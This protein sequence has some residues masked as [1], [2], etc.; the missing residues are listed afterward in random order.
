MSFTRRSLLATAGVALAAPAFRPA[1]AAG[2]AP[3]DDA[4][5]L[6]A[7]RWARARMER[8]IAR[9]VRVGVGLAVLPL[10]EELR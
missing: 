7:V 2:A 8:A 3:M 5:L 10:D 9:R 1:L 6:D 4:S